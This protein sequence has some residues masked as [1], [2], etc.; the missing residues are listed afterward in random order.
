MTTARQQ[1]R[2][3]LLSVNNMAY[4]E[5]KANAAIRP[6]VAVAVDANDEVGPHGTAGT[7]YDLILAIQN[8]KDGSTIDDAYADNDKV[9]LWRPNIGDVA[10]IILESGQDCDPS[11]FLT[12]TDTG[13]FKVASSTDKRLFR[14]METLTGTGAADRFVRAVRVG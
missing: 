8:Q 10:N 1:N 12:V 2:I 6:G 4:D 7:I 11:D 3:D 13:T 9:Y 14:P 5:K